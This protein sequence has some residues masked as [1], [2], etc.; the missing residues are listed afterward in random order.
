KAT[1]P[2]SRPSSS[3]SGSTAPTPSPR[4]TLRRRPA[5][6]PTTRATRNAKTTVRRST[7]RPSGPRFTESIRSPGASGQP[8]S[9]PVGS[10]AAAA[11]EPARAP[12]ARGPLLLVL[13]LAIDAALG[14]RVGEQPLVGDVGGA[15]DA[16][17]VGAGGDALAGPG[18][19]AHVLEVLPDQRVVHRR[20]PDEQRLV[21]CLVDALPEGHL[22]ALLTLLC[23]KQRANLA[24]LPG[25]PL[26]HHRREVYDLL[27]VECGHVRL[28]PNVRAAAAQLHV[29]LA[30]NDCTCRCVAAAAAP[31]RGEPRDRTAPACR[32]LETV[33]CGQARSVRAANP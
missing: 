18:D 14:G 12:S 27:R 4:P 24:Q 11:G 23:G 1:R 9:E 3:M 17:A 20:E 5:N 29:M 22:L 10:A 6:Q 26:V 33:A 32:W 31:A 25:P 15:V 19:V 13:A 28:P 7:D 8:P 2:T 21:R 16:L 30:S